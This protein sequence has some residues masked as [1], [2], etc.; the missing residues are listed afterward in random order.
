MILHELGPGDVALL[1]THTAEGGTMYGRS[2]PEHTRVK[3]SWQAPRD[4]PGH[5]FV[6]V[7]DEWDSA[8]SEPTSLP[9]TAE[10]YSVERHGAPQQGGDGHEDAL[11]PL[12][13]TAL[14]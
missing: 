13:M 12:R 5:T 1:S 4:V 14:L 7:W 11:D 9:A 2:L 8:W 3:V 6:R 10:C